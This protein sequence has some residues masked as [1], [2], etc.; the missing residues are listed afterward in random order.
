[1]ALISISLLSVLSVSTA[2]HPVRAVGALLYINP[3][4]TSDQQPGTILTYQVQVANIDPFNAWDITVQ[5]NPAVINPQT[6]DISGNLF[7]ANYSSLPLYEAINCVNGVGTG[8][9]ATDGPGLAHSSVAGLGSPPQTG[10]SSGLLFTITYKV[11]GGVASNVRLFDDFI[12]NGDTGTLVPYAKQDGHYGAP[13]PIVDFTWAPLNPLAGDLV[14]FNASSS[15]DPNPG[16]SIV[17]YTWNFGD[18]SSLQPTTRNTTITHAYNA[19]NGTPLVGNFQVTLTV[20]DTLGIQNS[21]THTVTVAIKQF[22]DISLSDIDINHDDNIALGAVINIAVQVVNKGTFGEVGFNVTATINGQVLGTPYVF[23]G[24]LSARGT[25]VA[26]FTW[27]TSR[28]APDTYEIAARVSPVVNETNLNNNMLSH[29]VV[30]VPPAGGSLVLFSMAQTAGL[31]P[32]GL[33]VVAGVV[34]LVRR[35]QRSRRRSIEEKL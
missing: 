16:A 14:T 4:T 21:N 8:C 12:I 6:V 15:Y 22:H 5:T 20:T 24:N 11:I 10:P 1:M 29:I 18:P 31:I 33:L 28:Y 3:P 13:L 23:A 26:H 32:L 2:I 35:A 25:T 9:L 7:A 30:I 19:N 27:D 17:S 34:T